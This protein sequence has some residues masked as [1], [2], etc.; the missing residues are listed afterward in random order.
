MAPFK[1][2]RFPR[3]RAIYLFDGFLYGVP[4]VRLQRR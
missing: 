1:E 4:A 3:Q 2:L